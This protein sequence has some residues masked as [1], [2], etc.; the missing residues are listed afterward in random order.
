[1][2][3]IF[4]NIEKYV[5]FALLG[6]MAVIVVSA[7]LEVAYT[8]VTRI[9]DPPGFFVGVE[10]LFALFG[11]FLMVL[12]GLELMAGIQAY[13]K[14]AD[15]SVHAEWILLIAMTAI[16]RK[17]VILDAATIDPMMLFG[18]GFVIIALSVGYYLVRRSRSLQQAD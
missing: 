3:K 6:L 11:L 9:F 2:E 12:I 10:D 1:M 17:I 8:I 16:T 7:T 5:A 13:L 4:D 14:V 18:V 15:R